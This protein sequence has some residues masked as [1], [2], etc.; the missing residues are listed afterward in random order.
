MLKYI[1]SDSLAFP[2]FLKTKTTLQRNPQ[3]TG[4]RVIEVL[5]TISESEAEIPFWNPTWIS[6]YSGEEPLSTLWDPALDREVIP[7]SEAT[8]GIA[9]HQV[10]LDHAVWKTAYRQLL[11]EKLSSNCASKMQTMMQDI[12]ANL[13]A[14]IE[15]TEEDGSWTKIQDYPA[16]RKILYS[17]RENL[18]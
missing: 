8:C 6:I 5:G 3:V 18:A 15:L 4:N 12:L 9:L 14:V 16:L 7:S 1:Y 10:Q 17:I 2:I 13:P 11:G